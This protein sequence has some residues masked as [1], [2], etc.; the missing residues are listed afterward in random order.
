VTDTRFVQA[1]LSDG[2]DH[3]FPNGRDW[4]EAEDG[5]LTILDGNREPLAKV[6]ADR[7]LAIGYR[8]LVAEKPTE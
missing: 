8:D 7:W 1:V 4:I 5:S 2:R 3:S 6:A